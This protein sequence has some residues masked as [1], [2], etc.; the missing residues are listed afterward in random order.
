MG[1]CMSFLSSQGAIDGSPLPQPETKTI[2]VLQIA[3]DVN[4]RWLLLLWVLHWCAMSSSSSRWLSGCLSWRCQLHQGGQMWS[5]RSGGTSPP[6]QTTWFSNC[7]GFIFTENHQQNQTW[8]YN[9]SQQCFDQ[10]LTT[11]DFA[12]PGCWEGEDLGGAWGWRGRDPH[13]EALWR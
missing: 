4:T 12:R 10:K 8:K 11:A 3:G 7:I 6:S 5:S 9:H 2:T 1:C 13:P